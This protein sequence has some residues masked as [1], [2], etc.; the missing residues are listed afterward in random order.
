MDK[1][2][3]ILYD[4]RSIVLQDGI[5][6]IKRKKDDSVYVSDVLENYTLLYWKEWKNGNIYMTITHDMMIAP[7]K[8]KFV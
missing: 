4:G 1:I 6:T 7:L 2:S 5:L 3:I 8:Y